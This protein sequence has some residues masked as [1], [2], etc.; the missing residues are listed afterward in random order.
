MKTRVPICTSS[1]GGSSA[2][3]FVLLRVMLAVPVLEESTQVA[4][5]AEAKNRVPLAVLQQLTFS[6]FSRKKRLVQFCCHLS[7]CLSLKLSLLTM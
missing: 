4:L 2:E 3:V 7:A 6:L 5:N 1:D